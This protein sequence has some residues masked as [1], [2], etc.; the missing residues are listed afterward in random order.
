MAATVELRPIRDEDLDALYA[1]EADPVAAHQ[2]AFTSKGMPDRSAFDARWQRIRK[3]EDARM[4]AVVYD[5]KVAGS[6]FSHKMGEEY[7]VGY[8]ISREHWGKGVATAA[9]LKYLEGFTYR[10]VHASA[11]CDNTASIRVLEKCGFRPCGSDKGFAN[12]RGEE[13]EELLFVLGADG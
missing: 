7:H 5:G 13:I 11:A 8:W 6:V 3:D 10:P 9:L 12:A 4:L 2:A 1:F